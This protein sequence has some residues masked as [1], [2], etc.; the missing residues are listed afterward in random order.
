MNYSNVDINGVTISFSE[1][2]E[3]Q[4]KE[5]L[6]EIQT[7]KFYGGWIDSSNPSP[8]K[9]GFYIDHLSDEGTFSPNFHDLPFYYSPDYEKY[10]KTITNHVRVNGFPSWEGHCSPLP[11]RDLGRFMGCLATA[12][13]ELD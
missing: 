4:L 5:N 11:W 12:K 2:H 6:P 3:T 1:E 9:I 10:I 13:D 7:V 8:N